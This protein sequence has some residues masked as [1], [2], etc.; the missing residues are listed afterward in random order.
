MLDMAELHKSCKQDN[1]RSHL[2]GVTGALSVLGG[3]E[4]G[5]G[6][7]D[8]SLPKRIHDL[9][10]LQGGLCRYQDSRCL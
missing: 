2:G 1:L 5:G 3:D 4:H 6:L 7:V 10:H 9:A 8:A